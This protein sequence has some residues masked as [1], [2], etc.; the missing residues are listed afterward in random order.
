MRAWQ[1]HKHQHR[2]LAT[3]RAL[4]R[5]LRHS[6]KSGARDELVRALQ[7]G[8]AAALESLLGVAD[9]AAACLSAV[10]QGACPSPW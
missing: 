8:D 7:S 6:G 4:A 2:P 10:Q 9:R 1:R 5:Q 3:R